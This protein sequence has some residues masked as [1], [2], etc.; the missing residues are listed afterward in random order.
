[1]EDKGNYNFNLIRL[2]RYGEFDIRKAAKTN[3][4]M[5]VEEYYKMLLQFLKYA[6]MT[7]DA[8][9][10]IIDHKATEIDYKSI[11]YTR[12]LLEEMGC[13]KFTVPFNEIISAGKRGHGQFAAECANKIIAEF[14]ELKM[15]L[16]KENKEPETDE[17]IPGEE[18][19]FGR[20]FELQSLK[21]ALLFLDSE[22]ANRKLRILAIDDAPVMLK[23]ISTVLSSQY[24]V[25]GMTNPATIEKFL[26][27]ITPDLFL[28]D[29]RMP[30]ISGFE[31]IPIIRSYREHKD[32]PII[33][34]TSMGTQEHVS[35]AFTLGACDF[36]V[37]PFQG[38]ILQKKIAKH[39]KRKK[40]F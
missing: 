26:N 6:T 25:Y 15:F 10:R 29:Y 5:S 13:H 39:I 21:N 7:S 27:H 24:K 31:L 30:E 35:A 18:R 1:M 17:D 20:A 33:I 3:T 11:E 36:V 28:I 4:A 14:I 8:L 16:E 40:L 38:D 9:D 12:D 2:L 19:T 22:E 34:L 37:K 32:T 23:V